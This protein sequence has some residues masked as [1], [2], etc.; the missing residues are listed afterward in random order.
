MSLGSASRKEHSQGR[1]QA[2]APTAASF[3]PTVG[4]WEVKGRAG[5]V[6]AH[7]F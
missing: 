5:E 2:G 7:Q 6:E 3:H 4:L 1:V